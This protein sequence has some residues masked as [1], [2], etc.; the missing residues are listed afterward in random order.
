LA[1]AKSCL[2][3]ALGID[4]PGYSETTYSNKVAQEIIVFYFSED[5]VDSID[6][7]FHQ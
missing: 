6:D 4:K 3:S 1:L 7:T 5:S 2:K